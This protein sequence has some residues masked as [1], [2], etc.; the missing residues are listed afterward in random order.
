MDILLYL[1][2]LWLAVIPA[3]QWYERRQG[4]EP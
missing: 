2:L 3:L 1:A 4:M